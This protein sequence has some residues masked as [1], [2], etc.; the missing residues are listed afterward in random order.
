ME[1]SASG[2]SEICEGEVVPEFLDELRAAGYV[3]LAS[4]SKCS[5][6]VCVKPGRFAVTKQESL[7]LNV[8]WD[9]FAAAFLEL[10]DVSSGV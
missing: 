4:R 2:L 9:L 10:T 8:G 3:V 5:I 1:H 6:V 7:P